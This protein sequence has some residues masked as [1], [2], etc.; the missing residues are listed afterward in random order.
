MRHE[1]SGVPS[2]PCEHEKR[3][4]DSNNST[5]Q[6][7]SIHIHTSAIVPLC[8]CV[9]LNAKQVEAEKREQQTEVDAE[10]KLAKA[11][12]QKLERRLAKVQQDKEKLREKLKK[13]TPPSRDHLR[14]STHQ[15]PPVQ[16][17][18]ITVSISY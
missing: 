5:L 1:V 18:A 14:R 8:V 15:Q 13:A 3:H 4:N 7:P 17:G 10:A 12:M 2:R 6:Y 16:R 9:N 11:N